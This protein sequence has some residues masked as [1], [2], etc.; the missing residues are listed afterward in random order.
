[1]STDL[2]QATA[3]E[4]GALYAAGKA[5]PVETMTAVLA[6]AE[7][8][9]PQINALTRV[10]AER[11]LEAARASEARWRTGAALSPL[12]GVPVSIK[13]LV[14]VAGWPLSMGSRLTDKAPAS[15]DAPAVSRLRE[16]GT[17]VFAQ[18]TSPEYGY[19]GVTDSPLHGV[20]RNPWNLER[21]PGGSSGGA[22]AAV[23]AGF[24]PLAIGTDGG[25]SVR[26]PASM[27]GLTGLKATFGRVPAWPASMHGDLANTGPMTRTALD[28]ALMMNIIARPDPR[29]PFA[30]PD[31]GVDYV[32][33]LAAPLAGRKVAFLRLQGGRRIDDQVMAAVTRAARRFEDF[34]CVVE[35]AAAPFDHAEAGAVWVT[36][37]MSSIQ[38]LLQIYPEARHGEFDP[39][40]LEQARTG[41]AFTVQTLV[42]AHV[43]RREIAH[44]WNLFF[45]RYDLL[46]GP[47]LAV[48]PWTIGRNAPEGPGGRPN[49]NWAC[50]VDFNLTRHPAASIPCGLSAEG[51]P[52]GLQIAAG[53]YRDALV[54]AAAAAFQEAQPFAFSALPA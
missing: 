15:E 28:C 46:V 3:A 43:R 4:L 10:D 52:I 1:M 39:G 6:R 7:T 11:A 14:K 22:G 41:A 26:I 17:L 18:T 34:G 49:L 48:L 12:D 27:C 5:S 16:A 42:D 38:R 37:W 31:D 54:L 50:T 9:N 19:K 32:A 33:A 20:T 40:L 8:V 45:Q 44:L 2:T 29:D 25:G 36:H 35:E 23:A 51:L 30:L 13:E 53:H 21:T 47:T 24:G